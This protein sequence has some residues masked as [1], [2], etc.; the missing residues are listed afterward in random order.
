MPAPTTAVWSTD[1]WLYE[2]V[3]TPL[4]AQVCF[5]DPNMI[6][7]ACFALVAPLIWGLWAGWPLWV[8]LVIAFIRQSLDCMDGAVARECDR[9]S[10]TGAILDVLEDTLTVGLMGTFL[11]WI[12]W[13]KRGR[14]PVWATAAVAAFMAWSFVRFAGYT[15][16]T[17][18]GQ[19]FIQS[20]LER[21]VH[22]NS[23]VGAMLSIYVFW[24]IR[25]Y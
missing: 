25:H 7:I 16:E 9:K 11:V 17:I 1:H 6:T 3:Y 2:T 21:F 8:L 20:A 22:D 5:V 12:M 14:I 18:Q 23:V 19:A 24:T 15:V 4:A 13:R 10:R